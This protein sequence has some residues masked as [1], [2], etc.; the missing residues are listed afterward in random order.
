[1]PAKWTSTWTGSG[2]TAS[3]AMTYRSRPSPRSTPGPSRYTCSATSLFAHS[4]SRTR[5]MW[6]PSGW[7][8]SGPATTTQSRANKIQTGHLSPASLASTRPCCCPP[9]RLVPSILF[10]TGTCSPTATDWRTLCRSSC[11]PRT[12]SRSRW[13]MSS[14]RHSRSPKPRRSWSRYRRPSCPSCRNSTRHRR[15]RRRS[16]KFRKKR[17]SRPPSCPKSRTRRRRS[18]TGS[19]ASRRWATR[20]RRSGSRLR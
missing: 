12:G 18:P 8:T 11:W 20:R 7:P 16:G 6:S 15:C 4:T 19:T 2:E 9:T 14:M 13:R 3:G 5:T 10:V 17:S 1:M